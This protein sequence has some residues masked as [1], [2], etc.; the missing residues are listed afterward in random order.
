MNGNKKRE[1]LKGSSENGGL[2]VAYLRVSTSAQ[3]ELGNGLDYGVKNGLG[4]ANV[5]ARGQ[6]VLR[7]EIQQWAGKGQPWWQYPHYHR[8]PEWPLHRPWQGL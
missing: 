7:F 2:I 5:V 8:A 4:G 1:R 3:D 6:P